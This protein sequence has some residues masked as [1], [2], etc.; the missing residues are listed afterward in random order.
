MKRDRLTPERI[1]LF[2][3]PAES[4]QA[5]YWDSLAPRLA[6]RATARAKSFIFESKLNRQ[7]IRV[8]LGDVRA[9]KLDDARQEANRLQTLVGLGIDPGEQERERIAAAKAKREEARLQDVTVAEAWIAY[10][11]TRKQRWSAR[12]LRNHLTLAKAGGEPRKSGWH[13]GEPKTTRPG[14]L[15]SLMQRC[16]AEIDGNVMKAWLAA[17]IERGP[18]QAEQAFRAFRTFIGWCAEHPDYSGAAVA[19]ACTSKALREMVPKVKPKDDVLQKEQI[20]PWF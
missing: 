18:S 3:C 6:V 8:T 12:H 1:R 20:A 4:G 14:P 16:L 17:E 2:T 5:F 15:H 13:P 19:D 11:E 7:T 10:I 9:W